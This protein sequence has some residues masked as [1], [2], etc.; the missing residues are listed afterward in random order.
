MDT[1]SVQLTAWSGAPWCDGHSWIVDEKKI[2]MK[3]VTVVELFRVQIVPGM[4]LSVT[5][6]RHSVI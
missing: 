6:T 3:E 5:Q 2:I 4:D 1:G